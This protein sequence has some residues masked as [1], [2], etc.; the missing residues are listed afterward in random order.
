MDRSHVLPPMALA[1][2]A[3]VLPLLA[4]PLLAPPG[5][6]RAQPAAEPMLRVLLQ[7]SSD[8]SLQAEGISALRVRDRQGRP[9]L[10]RAANQPLQLR[11]H[12]G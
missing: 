12:Q 11:L 5:P 6:L 1:W 4:L 10:E 7:E 8:L 9:L 2:R 3:L